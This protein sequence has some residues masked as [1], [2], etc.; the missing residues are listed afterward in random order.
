MQ[1]EPT[2]RV[3]VDPDDEPAVPMP[4]FPNAAGE[5][6]PNVVVPKGQP[7]DAVLAQS[8]AQGGC[9]PWPS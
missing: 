4:V 2:Q 3:R 1:P 5:V 7:V 9:R 8:T 6:D